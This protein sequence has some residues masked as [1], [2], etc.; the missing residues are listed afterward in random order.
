MFFPEEEF[1]EIKMRVLM[2]LKIFIL[3]DRKST[4][5]VQMDNG[6]ERVRHSCVLA[7]P[8]AGWC[9]RWCHCLCLS[10]SALLIAL[11]PRAALHFCILLSLEVFDLGL[12]SQIY[13][14]VNFSGRGWMCVNQLEK[15]KNDPSGLAWRRGGTVFSI[16][17]ASFAGWKKC[18]KTWY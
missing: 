18:F 2:E 16:P 14:C 3:P 1:C 6:R 15:M 10:H 7:V 17:S 12:Y 11:L 8:S 4:V 9:H 13:G 5:G